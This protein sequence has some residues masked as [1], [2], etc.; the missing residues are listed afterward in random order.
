MNVG[1]SIHTPAFKSMLCN[2]FEFQIHSKTQH[3]HWKDLP[4][5]VSVFLGLDIKTISGRINA[6]YVPLITQI[7]SSFQSSLSKVSNVV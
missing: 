6:S 1:L 4:P 7:T 2:P 3:Q 5:F